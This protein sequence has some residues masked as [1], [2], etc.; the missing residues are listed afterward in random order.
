MNT[1]VKEQDLSIKETMAHIGK[2][3]KE[4]ARTLA[5]TTTEQKN[6]SLN[7][8]AEAILASTKDIITANKLDI[9]AARKNGRDEAFID[10]LML[11]EKRIS[12]ISEALVSI[13]ALPDPVGEI[14]DDWSRPNG[15][16]ISRIRTPLGVIGIIYESRPNVTA[17]AGGM[18]LKAGN[19]A[20]LRGGSDGHESSTAIH[21]AIIAGLKSTGLPETAIQ[22]VPTRDR[23]AVGEMLAGLEGAI[24]VIVPRGGKSLVA[25][26]EKEA[27]V[28]VFSHLEGICHV[29][30]DSSAKPE[31]AV[32]VTVN[33]KMRR[34][35]ICG[36]AETLLLDAD[37]QRSVK[38]AIIDGLIK[39]GCT[40]RADEKT[41]NLNEHITR[42]TDEDWQTEYLSNII[43]IKEVEGV[44]GA[45]AHIQQYSSNH[46]EAIISE[47]MNAVEA[48][49]R[50]VD[51]AI[52]MHN[53]STQFADGG[54]FG[55]GAEIGIATGKMHARGPVGVEQLTSFKYLVRGHGQTRPL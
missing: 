34:T 11:D 35:G 39:A 15:L 51:S 5:V 29:Y 13:A 42:A 12:S 52:L 25:R 4:A 41:A 27:R 18:C 36:A 16:H 38:I 24:D 7:N 40:I 23:A 22:L 44:K 9:E 33:A 45:I 30:V 8:M 46:T 50:E 49:F 17:D 3:A 48:F 1:P 19:A 37:L 28:P 20:I 54:E 21:H 10:R 6:E 43:S 26:V 55:M 2:A 31:M 32:E 53:A 47:D 14:T